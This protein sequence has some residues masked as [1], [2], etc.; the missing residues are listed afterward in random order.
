MSQL[1]QENNAFN[2]SQGAPDFD[3]SADL[4]DLVHQ[5]MKKGRNQYAPMMGVYELREQISLKSENLYHSSYDVDSEITV[6]AGGSEAI[7]SARS[8]ERRVG[9]ECRSGL[10]SSGISRDAKHVI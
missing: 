2:L 10:S 3:C 9:K 1:A 8:E 4:I 6:T 7:F 5:Y